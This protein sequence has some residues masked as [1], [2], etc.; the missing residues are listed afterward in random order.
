MVSGMSFLE[1]IMLTYI[2]G[3]CRMNH[4]LHLPNIVYDN[5]REG[6]EG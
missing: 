6:R 2:F 3:K 1:K 5:R 4:V